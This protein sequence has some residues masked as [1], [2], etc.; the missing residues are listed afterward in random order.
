MQQW[1][2][3]QPQSIDLEGVRR[4]QVRMVSGSVDVVGRTEDAEAGAAQV[5]V[6][7]VAGPLLVTL[8]NGTLTVTHERLTWGGLLDW[9]GGRQASA[10]VSVSVPAGCPVELGVVSADAVVSGIAADEMV[11]EIQE[12]LTGT[13][14]EPDVDRVLATVLFTDIVESTSQA[15]ALGDRDWR[16]LLNRHDEAIRRELTRFRGIMVKGTGDGALA[17]FDGPARAIQCAAAIRAALLPGD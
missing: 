7:E 13:R 6:T 3:E 16:E 5:E 17:T 4:L 15:V 8:E 9:V 14:S 11:D 1:R 2:I 10:V 12:F